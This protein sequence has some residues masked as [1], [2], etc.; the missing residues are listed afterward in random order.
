M[1]IGQC[2]LVPEFDPD[3]TEYTTST[4]NASEIVTAEKEDETA[5]LDLEAN[6]EA[7]DSGDSVDL[8]WGDN[9]IKATVTDTNADGTVSKEY[10]ATVTRTNGPAQL[11]ALTIGSLTLS[12]TFDAD[13]TEYTANTSNST[14][15]I[16]ATAAEGLEV[17]IMNGETEVASGTAAT[18]ETGENTVTITV[19]GEHYETTVYT[20]VVTKS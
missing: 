17:T 9:T 16:T 4:S 13:I 7:F 18:W 20:V 1:A 14:N 12:P 5:T 3:V 19:E 10:T 8:E 6:G 2:I 11:S 15:T